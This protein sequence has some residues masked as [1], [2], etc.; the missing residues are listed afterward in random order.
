MVM[1]ADWSGLQRTAAMLDSQVECSL[2][3]PLVLEPWMMQMGPRTW[4]YVMVQPPFPFSAHLWLPLTP[5][6]S[7]LL[8]LRSM[9]AQLTQLHCTHPQTNH[10]SIPD[11]FRLGSHTKGCHLYTIST[12][13][14]FA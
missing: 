1:M 3:P 2:T 6:A 8:Q 10:R 13:V 12:F 14:L 11:P 4:P 9:L 7:T 5:S